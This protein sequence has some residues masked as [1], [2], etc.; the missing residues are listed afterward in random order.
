MHKMWWGEVEILRHRTGILC[1]SSTFPSS[2][3]KKILSGGS[4]PATKFYPY[5]KSLAQEPI[6]YFYFQEF[7]VHVRTYAYTC[8]YSWNPE[9]N[10]FQK[11][12]LSINKYFALYCCFSVSKSLSFY[13]IR[14]SEMDPNVKPQTLV[15]T[16]DQVNFN[17]IPEYM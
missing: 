9:K 13:F 7:S 6:N 14:W 16:F 4:L 10:Y 2:V 5:I 11:A 17:S 12:F 3:D 1:K 15:E 8:A